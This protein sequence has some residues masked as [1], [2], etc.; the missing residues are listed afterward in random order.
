MPH[1]HKISVYQG[2]GD[3]VIPLISNLFLSTIRS[4]VVS[5][6]S[7]GTQPHQGQESTLIHDVKC[8]AN[9]KMTRGSVHFSEVKGTEFTGTALWVREVL[10]I[11][12]QKI[13]MCDSHRVQPS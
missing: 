7:Q 3:T 11:H 12:I 8:P 5:S 1:F 10:R 2:V 13:Q 4:L 9:H 6:L